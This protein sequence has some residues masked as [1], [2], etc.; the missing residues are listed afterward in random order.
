[1]T[2]E[3]RPIHDGELEEY[4]RVE[5]AAFGEHPNALWLDL[6]REHIELPGRQLDAARFALLA[7]I[8]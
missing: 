2:F 6:L 5:S 4:A 1:M 7:P 3:S 8:G